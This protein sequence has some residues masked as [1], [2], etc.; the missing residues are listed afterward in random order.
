MTTIC[1]GSSHHTFIGLV[2]V[3]QKR[4]FFKSM[5]SFSHAN[6]F[7]TST[8]LLF[9]KPRR[10]K[11]R[12]RE[13][14]EANTHKIFIRISTNYLMLNFEISCNNSMLLN[15]T[16]MRRSSCNVQKHF[17]FKLFSNH[18]AIINNLFRIFSSFNQIY[19]IINMILIVYIILSDHFTRVQ[20]IQIQS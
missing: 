9:S 6:I 14:I 7:S 1:T 12:F 19:R 2:Q 15:L 16:L 10:R 13:T 18:E 3:N 11:Q 8:F 17:Y 20:Y 5:C 4:S